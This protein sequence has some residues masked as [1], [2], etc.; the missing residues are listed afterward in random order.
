[1]QQSL[2]E[3]IRQVRRYRHLTQGELAGERFSKSYVSS[4]EHERIPPSAEALRFFAE[5]LGQPDLN[6]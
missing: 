2:G 4:V 6:F 3:V 1:M 5:R